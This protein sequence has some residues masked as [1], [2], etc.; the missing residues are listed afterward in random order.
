MKTRTIGDTITP[1]LHPELKDKIT[2][3][4]RDYEGQSLYITSNGCMWIES[5]LKPTKS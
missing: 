1:R 2:E 3:I 4:D 5:E